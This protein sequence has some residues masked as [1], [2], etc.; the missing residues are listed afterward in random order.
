MIVKPVLYHLVTDFNTDPSLWHILL[1]L[2][3]TGSTLFLQKQGEQRKSLE[4]VVLFYPVLVVFIGR[5][6][7]MFFIMWY[8]HPT[9]PA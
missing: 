9:M 3:E 5:F 8:C 7:G 6:H 1:N 4:F 2:E